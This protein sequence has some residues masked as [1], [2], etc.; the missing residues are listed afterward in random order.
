VLGSIVL[1]FAMLGVVMF[2]P[3]AADVLNRVFLPQ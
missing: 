3:Q 2:V 1:F